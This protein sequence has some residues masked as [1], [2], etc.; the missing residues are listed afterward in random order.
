MSNQLIDALSGSD[1]NMMVF[2]KLSGILDTQYAKLPTTENATVFLLDNPV[3]VGGAAQ[4]FYVAGTTPNPIPTLTWKLQVINIAGTGQFN[5]Q[6]QSYFLPASGITP[7][8][9]L[10]AITMVVV[11]F[12]RVQ[13]GQDLFNTA[14]TG[15]AQGIHFRNMNQTTFNPIPT[16]ADGSAQNGIAIWRESVIDYTTMLLPV[17]GVDTWF[18]SHAGTSDIKLLENEYLAVCLSAQVNPYVAADLLGIKCQ[19]FG[20]IGYTEFLV[21]AETSRMK[22]NGEVGDTNEFTWSM[23]PGTESV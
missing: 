20:S 10:L 18:G 22:Q 19:M 7:V 3:S 6:T 16:T 4:I 15:I 9:P 1:M 5:P 14:G 12:V 8:Y 13:R 11:A 2:A 23:T 17:G 21:G